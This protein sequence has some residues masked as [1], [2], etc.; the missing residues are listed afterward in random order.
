LSIVISLLILYSTV[1][2]LR[3]TLS[4][5]MEGV[6]SHINLD[7]LAAALSQAEHV[8]SIH[9][10]HVWTLSSGRVLLSAHVS[11]TSR[12]HWD[13]ALLALNDLLR[14]DYQIEHA[15]LQP[16]TRVCHTSCDSDATYCTPAAP[17]SHDHE[18]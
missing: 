12:E 7:E 2:L 9:D 4:V 10:L 5:L 17:H 18:H 8:D 14:K 16:E 15:T 1:S 3:E 13:D 11:L 6:P